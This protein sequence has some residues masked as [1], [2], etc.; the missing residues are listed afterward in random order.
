MSEWRCGPECP[1]WMVVC[2]PH[3]RQGKLCVLDLE[4]SRDNAMQLAGE[5]REKADVWT[6]AIA[7]RKEKEAKADA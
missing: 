7:A 3:Y 1:A 4:Q 5:W 2:F 6:A